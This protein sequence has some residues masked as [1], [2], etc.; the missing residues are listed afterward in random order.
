MAAVAPVADALP[1]PFVCTSCRHCLPVCRDGGERSG[2]GRT[3][4]VVRGS[5]APRT[6]RRLAD[7]RLGELPV[8]YPQTAAAGSRRCGASE[9]FC[10]R[11]RCAVSPRACACA[12]TVR[13]RCG[14][15]D[16]APDLGA[17][18]CAM[19]RA[20]GR[21]HGR[22][23]GEASAPPQ[24]S[25]PAPQPDRH[26]VRDRAPSA[27]VQPQPQHH[28][29]RRHRQART[30]IHNRP[31]I[32]AVSN[33]RRRCSSAY[34]IGATARAGDSIVAIR[35]SHGIRPLVRGWHTGDDDDDD[36]QHRWCV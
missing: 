21:R 7:S 4:T 10:A 12:A 30:R 31:R 16:A 6:R 25:A 29:H 11:Q 20:A 24:S 19:R 8:P 5:G 34:A 15:F 2:C 36:R 17:S 1:A 32:D 33:A 13:S 23:D 18:A 27:V 3:G 14:S 22:M 35:E 28:R 9:A 26:V